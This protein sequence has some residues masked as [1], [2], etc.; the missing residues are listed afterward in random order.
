MIVSINF[1][2]DVGDLDEGQVH[3]LVADWT[4]LM[5]ASKRLGSWSINYNPPKDNDE[6]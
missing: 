3:D 6:I 1:D 2:L 5:R 4:Y